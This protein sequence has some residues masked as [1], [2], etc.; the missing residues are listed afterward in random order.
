MKG[1]MMFHQDSGAF[2][3]MIPMFS[4][5]TGDDSFCIGKKIS[6]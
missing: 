4:E 1:S 2:I 3:V 6:G 5:G